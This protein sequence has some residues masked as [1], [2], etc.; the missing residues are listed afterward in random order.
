MSPHSICFP[1]WTKTR[2]AKIPVR[3]VNIEFT[4]CCV[5]GSGTQDGIFVVGDGTKMYC[6]NV[7]MQHPAIEDEEGVPYFGYSNETLRSLPRCDKGG[8]FH[9][10]KC[11]ERHYLEGQDSEGMLFYKCQD[12]LRLGG[13]GGR[14]VAFTPP[15]VKGR[16]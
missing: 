7:G 1:C 14:F 13:V 12:T 11:K 15:D 6:K 16:V 2:G 4:V 9:C 5:C 3:T 10:E 8:S